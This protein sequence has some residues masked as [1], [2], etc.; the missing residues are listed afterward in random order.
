MYLDN[1]IYLVPGVLRIK[2]DLF[3][4]RLQCRNYTTRDFE[5]FQSDEN[6]GFFHNLN[7]L[8]YEIYN[9]PKYLNI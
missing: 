8:D 9:M 3:Y 6:M 7:L 2:L 5:Y 1:K 4:L